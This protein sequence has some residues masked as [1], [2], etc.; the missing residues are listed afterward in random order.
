M[1]TKLLLKEANESRKQPPVPRHQSQQEVSQSSVRKYTST[2][3]ACTT[4]QPNPPLLSSPQ[5]CGLTTSFALLQD[6]II[7]VFTVLKSKTISCVSCTCTRL[8]S[9]PSA[10]KRSRQFRKWSRH[11]YLMEAKRSRHE[12]TN[13]WI[14]AA[15]AQSQERIPQKV[16]TKLIRRHIIPLSP[17]NNI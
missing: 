10:L 14:S 5:H 3:R 17:K 16:D 2:G 7:P 1:S 4:A 13:F 9:L 12:C 6:I 15:N 8:E 11:S